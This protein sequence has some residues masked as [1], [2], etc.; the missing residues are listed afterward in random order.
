MNVV[1]KIQQMN[2]NQTLKKLMKILRFNH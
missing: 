2:C 1:M